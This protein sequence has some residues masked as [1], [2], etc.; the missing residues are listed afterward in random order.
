MR[1]FVLIPILLCFVAMTNMACACRTGPTPQAQAVL[2]APAAPQVQVAPAASPCAP[3]ATACPATPQAFVLMPSAPAV[4]AAPAQQQ[5][6]VYAAPAA[7]SPCGQRYAYARPLS[8]PG[9]G[10]VNIGVGAVAEGLASIPVNFAV[11]TVDYVRCLLG[12][13]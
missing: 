1:R 6:L 11:C 5:V 4:Q 9:S 10:G 2:L 13:P 3:G 8:A 12:L 7:S